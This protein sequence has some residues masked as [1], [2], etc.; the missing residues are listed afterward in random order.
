MLT[1][2]PTRASGSDDLIW[3]LHDSCVNTKPLYDVVDLYCDNNVQTLLAFAL[4]QQ[5]II[6]LNENQICHK[7]QKS[8]DILQYRRTGFFHMEFIFIN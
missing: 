2:L 7:Q 1:Q 8:R 4:A 3:L 6:T 5:V